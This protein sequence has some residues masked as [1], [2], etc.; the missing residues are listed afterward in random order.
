MAVARHRALV[1]SVA[2]AAFSL[3]A[4]SSSDDT[5]DD[6]ASATEAP[7]ATAAPDTT[8]AADPVTILVT[9]DD[10]VGSEGID[11]VVEGLQTLDG[12]E[13]VV[14]APAENQSGKSDTTTDGD[15]T[16][17]DATTASGYEAVSVNGTPADAVTVALDE[18]DITPDLV[19]SGINEGQNIGP[20]I[21]L[22]GTVG[23]ARTAARQGYPALA[24][25]QGI[26]DAITYDDAAELIV[27]WVEAN[28]DAAVAGTLDPNIVTSI[29]VPTCPVGEPR[30]LVEVPAAEDDTSARELLVV[31]CESTVEDPV[32]DIQGFTTGFA[33]QT[34]LDLTT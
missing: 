25:S 19:V 6:A 2:I 13:I 21:K 29:N 23:A 8:M 34:E 7:A 30:G 15:V 14:V 32:D 11:A 28:R 12:V 27:D 26:G 5:T 22:S 1:A 10:G 20:L 24:A 33:V 17:Q 9:N 18:L 16:W 4:C 3:A 31:D